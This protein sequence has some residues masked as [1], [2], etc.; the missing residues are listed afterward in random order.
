MLPEGKR[1]REIPKRKT[2]QEFRGPSRRKVQVKT[3]Y[4]REE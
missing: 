1:G 4:S 2:G 3:R